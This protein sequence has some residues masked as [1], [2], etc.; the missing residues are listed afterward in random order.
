MISGENPYPLPST[1]RPQPIDEVENTRKVHQACRE[2]CLVGFLSL[3]WLFISLL[4]LHRFPIREV[5]RTVDVFN[6][7]DRFALCGSEELPQLGIV[8][9]G[10]QL[11]I[12]YVKV[13]EIGYGCN[14][15]R[16]TGIPHDFAIL[17][18]KREPEEPILKGLRI[19]LI[20]TLLLGAVK[21]P[22][23]YNTLIV[24]SD[25]LMRIH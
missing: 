15:A 13:Q 18:M 6:D 8:P 12:A 22:L 19:W 3:P 10:P 5:Q 23:K 25:F 7:N 17:S 4:L 24:D 9:H 2:R 1:R 14:Q 11:K 16:L 20:P 21:A